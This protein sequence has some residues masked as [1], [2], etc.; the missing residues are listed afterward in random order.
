MEGEKKGSFVAFSFYKLRPEWRRLPP[1]ARERGIEQALATLRAQGESLWIRTYSTQ[2][3]RRDADFLLWVV[4]QE[5]PD[6]RTFFMDFSR[7][8][9]GPYLDQTYHYL[10]MT[11]QS[12]Y[13][14]GAPHTNPGPRADGPD[15]WVFVYPFVKSRE[16]YALP[17]ETRKKMMDEHI[18]AGHL[19]PNVKINT[20]YSFGLDDQEFVLAFE[21]DSPADFQ[22]L[23]MKLR[24]TEASRYTVRDTPIFTC[25]KRP[26]ADVLRSLS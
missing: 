16:W 11:R 21:T 8:D 17:F 12:M 7:T 19:F 2:G 14:K 23:V 6:I 10:A 26:L 24:E 18:R 25:L 3:F 13:L 9:M 20:T 1:D 15:E 5:L 22:A 4:A